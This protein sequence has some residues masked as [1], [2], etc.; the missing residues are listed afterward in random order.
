MELT[1]HRLKEPVAR[2]RVDH[3][4]PVRSIGRHGVVRIRNRDDLRNQ[5]DIGTNDSVRIA[6]AIYAFMM[7][8][9]DRGDIVI[10]CDL[11]ENPLPDRRM[12][13]HLA[14]FLKSQRPI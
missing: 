2:S 13:L 10:S 1:P 3:R 6:V 8:T 9:H 11:T 7:V 5:W 12:L 4:G 14:T